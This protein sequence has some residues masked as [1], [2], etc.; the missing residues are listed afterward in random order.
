MD[1]VWR[2][3]PYQKKLRHKRSRQHHKAV[4]TYYVIKQIL[5]RRLYFLYFLLFWFIAITVFL[6]LININLL[7]YILTTPV[8]R[9]MEK[10]DFIF[11]AYINF[12]KLD[13]PVSLSRAVFSLLLAIN[14]TMIV[15]L[16]RA[17]KQRPNLMKSN[18]GALLVIVGSS[19]VACGTSIIA[20]LVTAVAGTGSYLS[21]ER[22]AATQLIA[23]GANVL[24]IIFALWS[25]N[26][27]AKRI[28]A[29]GLTAPNT[30]S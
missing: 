25:I 8:L 12:F 5:R 11:D 27:L 20:P 7:V 19:C 28:L 16:W 29:L 18:S 2:L 4:K 14:L 24:G 1:V 17:G 21:A 9:L 30:Q 13:N 10:L 6:W 22:F 23:T 3:Q 26:S 15:F